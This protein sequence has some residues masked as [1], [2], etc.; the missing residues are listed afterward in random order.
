M[1]SG[2]CVETSLELCALHQ[3]LEVA[4]C[5]N[6]QES[7]NRHWRKALRKRQSCGKETTINKYFFELGITVGTERDAFLVLASARKGG[8]ES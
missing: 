6:V 3:N 1:L 5:P 4:S 2:L 8:F 7:I